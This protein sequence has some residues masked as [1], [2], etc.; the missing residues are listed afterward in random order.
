MHALLSPA[1]ALFDKFKFATKFA[2]IIS[3][4]MLLML[5]FATTVLNTASEKVSNS[6]LQTEGLSYLQPL[7]QLGKHIAQHRGMTNAYLNGAKIFKDKILEKRQ[8]INQ[9]YIELLTLDKNLAKK[10]G[11]SDQA[12]KLE[13]R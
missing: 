11:L 13:Q 12:S 5:F 6:Q 9:D 3:V 2:I 1:I 7:R 10:F 4:S 8:Q